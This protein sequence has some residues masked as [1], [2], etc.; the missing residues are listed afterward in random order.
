MAK[1]QT[2][3]TLVVH[4]AVGELDEQRILDRLR[5]ELFETSTPDHRFMTDVWTNAETFRVRRAVPHASARGKIL[6]LHISQA[7]TKPSNREA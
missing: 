1:S 7:K 6:P 5:R 4:P 2:R 3:L